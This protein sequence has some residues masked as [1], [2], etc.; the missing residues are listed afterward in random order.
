MQQLAVVGH[1]EALIQATAMEIVDVNED[2]LE[3]IIKL[4]ADEVAN[5]E[6]TVG[7][8]EKTDAGEYLTTVGN[9]SIS[10]A[11]H[12]AIGAVDNTAVITITFTKG[13]ATATI[14]VTV[15]IEPQDE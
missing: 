11:K 14:D 3:M 10:L 6:V 15:T 9:T 13:T 7:Y 2:V 1:E 4:I 12:A 5:T 8:A